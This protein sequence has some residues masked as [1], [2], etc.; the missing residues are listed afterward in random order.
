MVDPKDDYSDSENEDIEQF[1]QTNELSA[2]GKIA[3]L[4]ALLP[5]EYGKFGTTFK[6]CSMSPESEDEAEEESNSGD[7][8]MEP[9]TVNM[10]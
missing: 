1:V 2:E 8:L 9:M 3:M 10:E 4:Q 5:R 7:G 6:K